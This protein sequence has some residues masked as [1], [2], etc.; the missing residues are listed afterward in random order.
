MDA[1]EERNPLFHDVDKSMGKLFS[2]YGVF[3]EYGDGKKEGRKEFSK[4]LQE[5]KLSETDALQR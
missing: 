1:R 4:D 2:V 5:L 3:K